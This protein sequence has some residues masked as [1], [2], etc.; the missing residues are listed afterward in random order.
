M[1]GYK[2]MKSAM[3]LGPKLAESRLARYQKVA[4]ALLFLGTAQF[5]VLLVLSEAIS[6]G[7]SVSN[8]FV[9]DLGVGVTA[10][11]FNSSL[12]L[13]G[14]MAVFSG[15]FV[16]RAFGA[17]LFPALIALAGIGA[18]GAAVFPEGNGL[19]HSLS[20]L[21][22]FLF[23]GLTAIVAYKL[24]K[25]PLTYISIVMGVLAIVTLILRIDGIFLGLGPGGIERVT[26]Y[27][28]LL[29]ATGFGG[30]LM[31]AS[32]GASTTS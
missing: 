4:G 6:P 30:H 17:K 14:L 26:T 11:I 24:E 18:I 7:Y 27:S 15:Y 32:Q 19:L 13:L 5:L 29:W 12:A 31:Q 23:G 22:A 10:S 21:V 16:Q 9:S 1:V 25:P 28:V 20:Q 2:R 3:L 8:N